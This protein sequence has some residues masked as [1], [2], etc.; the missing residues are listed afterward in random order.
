MKY[1]NIT[2]KLL[3]TSSDPREIIGNVNRQLR[4]QGVSKEIRDEFLE[5]AFNTE[6]S[7]MLETVMRW[8]DVE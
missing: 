3:G 2:V 5:D 8:F 1:P 7:R 4:Q 6:G